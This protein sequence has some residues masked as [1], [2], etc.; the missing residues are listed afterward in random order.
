MA[1]KNWPLLRQID[2]MEVEFWKPSNIDLSRVYRHFVT[3]ATGASITDEAAMVAVLLDGKHYEADRDAL[4]RSV[5][6]KGIG[7]I[8]SPMKFDTLLE[9]HGLNAEIL[10]MTVAFEVYL[11]EASGRDSVP[12][13]TEEKTDTRQPESMPVTKSTGSSTPRSSERL[14]RGAK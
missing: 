14:P 13:N 8:D 12:A 1:N 7:F 3:S 9:T 10:L 11:G 6:V 4:F 2:K 5:S